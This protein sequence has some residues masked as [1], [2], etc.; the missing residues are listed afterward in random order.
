MLKA[1]LSVSDIAALR[2]KIEQRALRLQE[3]AEEICRQLS[4]IGVDAC[5]AGIAHDESG[6]LRG[7]IRWERKGDREYLVVADCPYAV[8]VEFGAGVVGA[9]GTYPG[10]RPEWVGA[11]GSRSTHVN[12]DGSW[13]YYDKKQGRWRIT[14][15]Q[16]P[17]GFMSQGA[18]TVRQAIPIIAREVL[19]S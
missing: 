2:K 7:S 10:T 8:Y 16:V 19:S 17:Q 14:S 4:E 3:K 11:P 13:V 1:G 5:V 12:P 18:M 9:R 6:E 15:G